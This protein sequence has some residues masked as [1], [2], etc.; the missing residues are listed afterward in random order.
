MIEIKEISPNLVP[1][2]LLLE[3][4]PSIERVHQYLEGSLCYVAVTQQEIVG[5][6]VLNTIDKNRIELFNIAVLPENR[7]QV[8]GHK[9]SNL[10]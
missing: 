5:V 9:Y 7:N 1:Q 8:L 6:C 2:K 10:L 3:A 4:D